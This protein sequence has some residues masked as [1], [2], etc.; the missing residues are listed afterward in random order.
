M[1]LQMALFSKTHPHP[2]F[3]GHARLAKKET[4]LLLTVASLLSSDDLL[5]CFPTI[6]RPTTYHHRRLNNCGPIFHHTLHKSRL[7]KSR[8]R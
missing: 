7:R 4:G 6:S 1:T 8:K 5:M 3:H 2:F